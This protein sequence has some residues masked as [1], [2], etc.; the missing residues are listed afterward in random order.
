M[1][2]L[3][4][5]K[6]AV[7]EALSNAMD[8]IFDST[9]LSDV[10]DDIL[11]F[12]R[13]K[14][15][16][17][18]S[19]ILLFLVRCLKSTC[20]YPKTSE[21]KSIVESCKILLIDT[22]EPVRNSSAE[23]MGTLM[24]IVGEHQMSSILNDIDELRKAK[25]KEYFELADVKLKY[26][27]S[28]H[29]FYSDLKLNK[30]NVSTKLVPKT[31]SSNEP[32]KTLIK[33]LSSK[34]NDLQTSKLFSS[35]Y[36]S[37][38]NANRLGT[39]PDSKLS[40]FGSLSLK[41]TT[42]NIINDNSLKVFKSVNSPS[43]TPIK[44]VGKTTDSSNFSAV[45]RQELEELRR[46]KSKLDER[47]QK[48]IFEKKTLL[49]EINSLQLKNAQLTDDHT[50]DVLQ[51]KAKEIQL[52]RA[53]NEIDM[54]KSQLLLLRKELDQ[55]RLNISSR[56]INLQN[57]TLNDDKNENHSSN[58]DD[59]SNN[60]SLKQ[61]DQQTDV[62]TIN[63]CSYIE[64]ENSHLKFSSLSKYSNGF[65]S[66]GSFGYSNV[67]FDKSDSIS[68]WDTAADL[69]ARLKERIEQMKRADIRH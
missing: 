67:F 9:S 51:I 29:S 34:R 27:N 5:R 7:I 60:D 12:L 49:D 39:R 26:E 40:S 55:S 42:N 15:P 4:E 57:F 69:T 43:Q 8:A 52:V 11:E 53:R 54:M 23:V 59:L 20:I 36:C 47:L 35:K 18:R 1:E 64:K 14:N 21:I 48:E 50:R 31:V 63:S 45:D 3:K 16:Q 30:S 66:S 37:S 33:P 22:F 44:L 17:I 46:E 65:S 28:K 24:K 2:K 32:K 6:A 68:C 19:E 41:N 38:I 58:I 25:I 10:F 13:H 61:N 62:S 56:S